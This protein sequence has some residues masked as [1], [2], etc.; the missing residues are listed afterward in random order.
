MMPYS[1]AQI[2]L[3]HLRAL[4]RHA[5]IDEQIQWS[6]LSNQVDEPTFQRLFVDTPEA[7][8]LFD[9]VFRLYAGAFGRVPDWHSPDGPNDFDS[10]VHSGLW[11][12][13]NA[14]RSGLSIVDLARAFVASDEFHHMYGTTEV[15][16]GLIVAFY[17]NVL[18][19]APS[20][21]EISA[22]LETGLDAG[23]I[24]AGFTES[25]ENQVRL[26]AFA[27]GKMS[28]I[29]TQN[30]YTV[31]DDFPLPMD[32]IF[33]HGGSTVGVAPPPPEHVF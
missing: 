7:N 16:A 18:D 13:I 15:S 12:N 21:A 28:Q 24:L 23:Q 32:E 4:G 14:L 6:A 30:F 27:D 11:V 33:S 1:Q 25:P 22:W 29:A 8:S 10:S 9:P 5:T 31:D 2:D 20:A 17:N 3:F 26:A 19:R